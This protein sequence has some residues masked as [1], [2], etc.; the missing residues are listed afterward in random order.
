M[1]TKDNFKS[2]P[3]ELESKTEIVHKATLALEYLN[4]IIMEARKNT[5]QPPRE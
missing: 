2:T 3:L 1:M 5:Q 4:H